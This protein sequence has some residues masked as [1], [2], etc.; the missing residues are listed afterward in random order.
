MYQTLYKLLLLF[1]IIIIIIIYS[2]IFIDIYDCIHG[3]EFN[4][5]HILQTG[6]LHYFRIPVP[7]YSFFPVAFQYN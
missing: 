7:Y 6:L 1:I 3:N 4:S 2:L 5:T